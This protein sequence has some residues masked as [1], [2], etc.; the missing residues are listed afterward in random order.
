MDLIEA[1]PV[2][3]LLCCDAS[4]AKAL[5]ARTGFEDQLVEAM[6]PLR[7]LANPVRLR[8]VAA[9]HELGELC[10]CDASWVCDTS[11][12]LASHHLKALHDAGIVERRR[13]GKLAMY[14]LTPRGVR[15]VSFVLE[16]AA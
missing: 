9:L 16:Q 13:V 15:L 3:E 8:V 6:T 5:R 2:G 12:A 11:V 7:V 10:V 1:E 4:R 14:Q